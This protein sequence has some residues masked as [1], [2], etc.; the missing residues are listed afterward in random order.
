MKQKELLVLI[1][2]SL[3]HVS[4]RHLFPKMLDVTLTENCH[5]QTG[6]FGTAQCPIRQG[7][8]LTAANLMP[9][10]QINGS[11]PAV[12]WG[13]MVVGGDGTWGAQQCPLHPLQ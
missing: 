13:R 11:A 2:K 7:Q 3:R 9:G 12:G 10:N 4:R 5:P 8:W 6:I 1:S